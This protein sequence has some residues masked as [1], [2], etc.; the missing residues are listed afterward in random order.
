[1]KLKKMAFLAS[2]FCMFISSVFASS[3]DS[4][5]RVYISKDIIE[6]GDDG[7][8]INVEDQLVPIGTI[9]HDEQGYYL[10]C[11]ELIEKGGHPEPRYHCPHCGQSHKWYENCPKRKK[12]HLSLR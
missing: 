6:L 2:V 1:M 12:N 7:M 3:A 4:D 10:S 5:D 9:Y 11:E 8:Y